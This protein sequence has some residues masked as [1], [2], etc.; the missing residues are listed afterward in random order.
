M[1]QLA[2]QVKFELFYLNI[3]CQMLKVFS[4]RVLELFKAQQINFC[5]KWSFLFITI[6]LLSVQYV[7]LLSKFNESRTSAALT[8]S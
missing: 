7:L 5:L 2:M 8:P 6:I 3:N 4:L 1:T